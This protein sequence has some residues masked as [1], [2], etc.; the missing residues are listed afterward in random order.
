MEVDI[1]WEYR[2]RYHTYRYTEIKIKSEGVF[3]REETA[4]QSP[5]DGIVIPKVDQGERIPNKFDFAVVVDKDSKRILNEIENLEKNIIRQFAENNP[6]IL[7][8]NSDFRNKVQN[9]VNKLTDI[10]VNK[11]FSA[12]A[13][14]KSSLER[15]LYQRNREIF[16]SEGNRLYLE[17]KKKELE[18]LREK[19]NETATTIESTFS[20]IVVWGEDFADEKYNHTNIDKLTIDD[21]QAVEN[22]KPKKVAAGSEQSFEIAKDQV[23][24]RL[25]NNE[26]SWHVCAINRKDSDKLKTGDNISLKVDGIKELIPCT[27]ESIETFEDKCKVIV[28]FNRFVEK[29]VHLR[30]VKADLIVESIEGL[31]I[32]QRSLTNINIYDNTADI[33]LVRFNR[34]VKKRVQI[35]A[36]QDTF[37]IIDKLPDS[38]ETDP[39]RVFD[40]YVVNPLNIEEGQVID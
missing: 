2:N 5:Q 12:I 38:K 28:S 8:G 21:L 36:E 25:I 19:I 6:E 32:P 37:V 23:F 33:Y 31:K 34:A 15:L 11:S 17:N 7:S 4:V 13:D 30:H 18:L 1:P 40:I 35:I 20:G 39:V 24:A 14:V 26:I 10:A 27:V 16:E 3:I 22:T 29:T 9:E